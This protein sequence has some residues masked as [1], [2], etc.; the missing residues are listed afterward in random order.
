MIETA[1]TNGVRLDSWSEHY[2]L[3]QWR[4]AA[5]QCGIDLEHYLRRRTANEVL[6]WDHLHTGV[7]RTFLEEEYTRALALTYTPDCRVHGC[8]G[9]GLC[10]FE[11][12]Q[13]VVH[14]RTDPE[15]ER[16]AREPETKNRPQ[17]Q[18]YTC[19]VHYTRRGDSRF[20]GHLELLQLIFRALRRARLPVLFS[21]GFNPSPRV[22][23]SHALPVGVESL[24][25]YFDM[26]LT[27]PPAST[28]NI[29]IRLNEQ[30]PATIRVTGVQ[31]P[32]GKAA[33]STLASYEIYG[34]CFSSPELQARAVDFLARES[35][36]VDRYRKNRHR[37]LDLRPLVRRLEV[38]GED[39][40]CLDLLSHQGQPA[41]N[42]MEIL[43]KV[44][45]LS[46]QEALLV[47][48]LKTNMVE[49]AALA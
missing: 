1:W 45:G 34:S 46:H 15:V 48:I 24:V 25:E 42:P 47:R 41:A 16:P 9:C 11:I 7:E 38:T 43:E 27:R 17:Q 29:D 28:E 40:L 22:A 4:R 36:S 26:V 20:Y 6:P 2:S 10:D 35:F 23:F 44:L 49:M 30:L 33:L 13:P 32:V 21:S 18:G 19:R 5:A 8:Q 39:I 37:A 31:F 3:E 14:P 12:I